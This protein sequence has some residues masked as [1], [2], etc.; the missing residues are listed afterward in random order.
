MTL[1]VYVRTPTRRCELNDV[2]FEADRVVDALI[3]AENDLA[4]GLWNV[5]ARQTEAQF[6]ARGLIG[7]GMARYAASA[8]A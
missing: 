4:R 5:A 1:A 8:V 7:I 2:K 6:A 3:G